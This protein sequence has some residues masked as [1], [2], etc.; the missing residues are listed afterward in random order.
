MIRPAHIGAARQHRNQAM[1]PAVVQQISLQIRLEVAGNGI[2]VQIQ[3][4]HRPDGRSFR[5][6]FHP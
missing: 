2:R 6:I 3:L 1:L 4:L 5:I